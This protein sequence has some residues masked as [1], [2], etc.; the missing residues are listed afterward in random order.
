MTVVE[1]AQA[2]NAA[3]D[4]SGILDDIKD[5]VSGA[6]DQA[7]SAADKAQGKVGSQAC[8]PACLIMIQLQ[9]QSFLF[10]QGGRLSSLQ[11]SMPFM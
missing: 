8:L 5:S 2:K 3:P 4:L 6:G 9:H 7:S 1:C 10:F 11:A